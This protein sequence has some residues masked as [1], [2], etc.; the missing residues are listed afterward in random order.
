MN[1]KYQH[2]DQAFHSFISTNNTYPLHLHKNVEITMVLSGKIN[3][4]INGKEYDLSEGDIAIIF[5]NQP[6][7]YKTIE[8]SQILLF[9]F[10]ATFPGILRGFA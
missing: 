3:I 5:S 6:H 8:K 10:D 7:S 9:F 4:N 2:R 1:I